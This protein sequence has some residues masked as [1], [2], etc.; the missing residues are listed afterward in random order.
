MQAF[1]QD[2]L[3]FILWPVAAIRMAFDALG[4]GEAKKA[5]VV[6]VVMIVATG[7]AFAPGADTQS[8]GSKFVGWFM[9]L[10]NGMGGR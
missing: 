2:L 3:T 10:V 5:A 1:L 9:D 7:V 4:R 6:F 8:M